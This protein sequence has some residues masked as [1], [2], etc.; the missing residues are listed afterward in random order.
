MDW[1]RELSQ[2]ARQAADWA[3]LDFAIE[4]GIPHR[5]RWP[6]GRLAEGPIDA[7]Y[8]LKETPSGA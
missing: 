1:S 2:A 7:R 3:A 4:H 6:A 5:G 8:K